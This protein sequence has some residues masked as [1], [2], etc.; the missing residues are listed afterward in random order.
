M[1]WA[2]PQGVRVV[3][4]E[5]ASDEAAQL[6]YLQRLKQRSFDVWRYRYDR[7]AE[8]RREVN[9]PLYPRQDFNVLASLRRLI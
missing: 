9:S 6:V 1:G 4:D 2:G 5:R 8:R 3:Q 7:I